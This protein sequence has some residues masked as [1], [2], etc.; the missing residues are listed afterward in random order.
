MWLE[1]LS[2]N[3][4]ALSIYGAKTMVHL[5]YSSFYPLYRDLEES[6]A[7]ST[8]KRIDIT[9][10]IPNNVRQVTYVRN[11]ARSTTRWLWSWPI[12]AIP[13]TDILGTSA[14]PQLL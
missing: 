8:K 10:R 11:K 13:T 4:A 7:F 3:Y 12:V 2:S 6:E 5:K 1:V 9:D 14:L